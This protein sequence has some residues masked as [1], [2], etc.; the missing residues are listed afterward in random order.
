[1]FATILALF[2]CIVTTEALTELL[3]E[4]EFFKFVR[5]YFDKRAT[6]NRV[7]EFFSDLFLC[8]YCMSVWVA[9]FI[10]VLY[11]ISCGTIFSWYTD[12]FLLWLFFHRGSNFIHSLSKV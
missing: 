1:M 4:S 12:W 9:F 5:D 2:L 7:F 10:M 11:V 3:V 6:H 8:G